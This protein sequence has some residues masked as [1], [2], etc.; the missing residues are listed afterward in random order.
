MKDRETGT[1]ILSRI[2][3]DPLN[4]LKVLY[5]VP[6]TADTYKKEKVLSSRWDY[7]GRGPEEILIDE[8]EVLVAQGIIGAFVLE[9]IGYSEFE[10]WVPWR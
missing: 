8:V 9:E 6:V 5:G 7:Q 10:L 4:H 1:Q 2:E 3:K